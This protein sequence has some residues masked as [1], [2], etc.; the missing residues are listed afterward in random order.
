MIF[1]ALLA[2]TASA[3]VAQ[4]CTGQGDCED[5]NPCTAATCLSGQC[6]VIFLDGNDCDDGDPCTTGSTCRDGSCPR[7][8]APVDCSDGDPCT[9]DFCDS[10]LG[11][12]HAAHDCDDGNSC[13][14]DACDPGA[15]CVYTQNGT[16][17][18]NP[19]G[20][21]Y[22]KHLCEHSRPGGEF[23]SDADVRCIEDLCLFPPPNPPYVICQLFATLP[24]GDAC[25][26]AE[27]SLMTLA[28]NLCRGRVAPGDRARPPLVRRADD[29]RRGP[30]RRRR[31][32]V[33]S[34]SDRAV[35]P[36]RRLHIDRDR[37]GD[38]KSTRLNSSHRL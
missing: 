5:N 37:L 18:D 23:I 12:Q 31:G 4:Q 19:R 17:G 11:C 28:L 30:G 25:A 14:D 24:G 36:P 32:S 9:D 15:G 6:N 26:R 38:R 27:A 1:L 33:R 29:C 2:L 8:G 20:L 21:G 3:A 10:F 7:G 35:V 13:T 34:R 16:C 22:W